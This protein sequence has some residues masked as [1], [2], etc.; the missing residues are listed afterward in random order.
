MIKKIFILSFAIG[1]SLNLT[2]KADEGMWLPLLVD[3]LNYVDMQKMGCHLT[4]EEIYS[5]NHSSLKDAT[6]SLNNATTNAFCTGSMVSDEGLLFTNHHCGYKYIQ[7]NSTVENDYLKNGFWAMD[8]IDELRNDKLSATFLIYM[9]DVT[10]K[11]LPFLNNNMSELT[12]SATIDSLAAIIEVE[13]AKNTKYT[14][15]ILPFFEGNEFYMFVTQ[16]YK[17]IRLVGAPPE[18]IGKFGADADNWKWPRESGD[19]SIFRVYMAPDGS[20]AEYSKNNV[21]YKPKHFFPI[22]IKGVKKNDFAMVLGYPGTTDRFMTS[23]GVEFTINKYNPTIIKIRQKRLILMDEKMDAHEDIRFKYLTKHFEISNYFKYYIGQ[24]EQLEE[25]SI[26]DKKFTIEKAFT[27][28]CSKDPQREEKY[29]IVFKDIAN[30]Y[31]NMGKYI[32]TVLYYSEAVTRGIEIINY[33]NTFADLAKLLKQSSNTDSINKLAQNLAYTAKIYFKNYDIETD[34]KICVAM[35]EMFSDA[36][37]DEFKADIFATIKNK[38]NGNIYKYV[39]Q[40]YN[41]SIFAN[42]DKVLKFLKNPDIKKLEKDPGYV[43][44]TSIYAKRKE[45]S[46]SYKNARFELTKGNRLFAEGLMEMDKEKKFYPNANSTMRLTY[47]KVSDYRPD[48]NISFNYYTTLSDLMSKEDPLNPYFVVPAKLKQLYEAKDYGKYATDGE[49]RVCFL[50]NNDVTGGVS[51]APVINANGEL[52]GLT[53]DVNW[54]ATCSPILFN[55]NYQRAINVDIKYVL[56][57]TDKYAG[58]SNIIKELNIIE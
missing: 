57:I 55:Q 22:S 23:Y 39:S 14:A 58:A 27:E 28:W 3:R 36:I 37:P 56:F 18:T 49:M 43:V 24:S 33:T 1:L 2:V 46:D 50:T 30:A 41:K 9:E 51:G 29:G 53:F 26:Y 25:L 21:P 34:K 17:D 8:K 12:R 4:A 44:M 45:I 15:K 47:G 35:M 20:P 6:V 32:V 16:T 7:N 42:E 40:M 10:G 5:V 48:A 11:I 38:Y 31:K 54:E 52:T 19:F 13:T